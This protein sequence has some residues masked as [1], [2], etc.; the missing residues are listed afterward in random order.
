MKNKLI[1]RLA[2]VLSVVMLITSTVNT[3]FA[4]I[5][6]KT[7]SI[8]NTFTPVAGATNDLTI[9]KTV[10]HPLG[11]TYVILDRPDHNIAFPF[12]VALGGLYANTTVE[13]SVGTAIADA[14]GTIQVLVKPN[15]PLSIKG[16]DEGTV[17]T[18]TE[19]DITL[20]GFSA[21]G[22]M[23]KQV[24]M[25]ANGARVDFVNV[26]TPAP[27]AASNIAVVGEKILTGRDWQDGD[28]FSFLLEQ[29]IGGVWTALG[30]KTITYD[31]ANGDFNKFTFSDIVQGLAFDKAGIHNF[32]MTEVKGSLDGVDY[33]ESVNTF[34]VVVTDVD[35][36]GQLEISGVSAAGNATATAD[37]GSY[38]VSVVFNNSFLPV[39]PPP[40]A[41][42]VNIV[43][44]KTVTNTGTDTI[45][46]EGFEFVLAQAGSTDGIK[47]RTN[48]N[49]E[50]VFTL[51]FAKE[52][53]G[54]YTYELFETNEGKAGVTYSTDRHTI[55]IA[56][57]EDTVSNKMVAALTVDGQPANGLTAAFSY[58]NEYSGNVPVVDPT[59]ISVPVTIKKTV[60]NTGTAT[61]GPG[62][63]EFVL[64]DALGLNKMTVESDANGEAAFLLSFTKDSVGTHVFKLYETDEGAEGVTYDDKVYEIVVTVT[65]GT[66]NKLYAASA[67]DGTSAARIVAAFENTYHAMEPSITVPITVN[68]TVKSSGAA[69]ISPANFEFVLKDMDSGSKL[70]VKT[71][72]NGKAAFALPFTSVDVGKTYTYE[73]SEVKGNMAGVTYDTEVYTIT[74]AITEDAANHTLLAALTV[75]GKS[76]NE[77]VADFENLYRPVPSPEPDTPEPN[78]PVDSSQTGDDSKLNFWFVMMVVSAM[79][80]AVLFVIDRS[81]AKKKREG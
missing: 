75:N 23:S 78:P 32:R 67:V 12:T 68:K 73:L 74:V 62:G 49:G 26:Y 76:V 59:P 22:D 16:I 53:A 48:T 72:A 37:N 21:A 5:V 55:T 51:T 58:T 50:A 46:P 7:D 25:T 24:T 33:D 80:T 70:T 81:Y 6:T 42:E 11:D 28:T 13:T 17:V 56:V 1:R 52:Q 57:T 20:P 41:V 40:D 15:T 69:T 9:H 36:N 44:N 63:F 35:M 31:A 61:M 2:L 4:Y 45:G 39:V 71:D 3:S 8:V 66:D 29:N 64:E 60:K 19:Q 47:K 43:V 54:E 79:T 65:K 77:A 30:T 18:V 14:N 10:E 34:D 38:T 27:V